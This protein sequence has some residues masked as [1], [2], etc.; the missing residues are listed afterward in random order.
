VKRIKL[1]QGHY[2]LVDDDDYQRVAAFNWRWK[3]PVKE[4]H[5]EYADRNVILED[6]RRSKQLL[7][8]FILNIEDPKTLVDHKDRNG[9]NC[10]RYNLRQAT[11]LQNGQ[12]KTLKHSATS[13]YKGLKWQKQVKKWQVCIQ[14]AVGP[15]KSLGLYTDPA[16]AA[17]VYDQAALQEFGE[18]ACTN[19]SLGLLKGQ[20][21]G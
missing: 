9:L 7:H 14:P 20:H 15:R 1:T 21:N 18:F 6:G 8:R 3:K 19:F 12:N 10:Q 16:K 4:S 2:A 5:A 13:K 17:S 11:T